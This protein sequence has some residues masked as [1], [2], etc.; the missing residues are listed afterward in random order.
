MAEKCQF[1]SGAGTDLVLK[2]YQRTGVRGRHTPSIHV[3]KVLETST[4]TSI[5]ALKSLECR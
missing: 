1:G 4:D 5:Y 2:S 3:V